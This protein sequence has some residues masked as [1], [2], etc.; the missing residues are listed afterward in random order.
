MSSNLSDSYNT[1]Q[2]MEP[3][4]EKRG[5]DGNYKKELDEYIQMKKKNL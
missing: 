1:N 2:N 4:N 3:L 5:K